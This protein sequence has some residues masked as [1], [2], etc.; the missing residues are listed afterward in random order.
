M[1]L[2]HNG[3]VYFTPPLA[4]GRQSARKQGTSTLL[5]DGVYWKSI[6]EKC[7]RSFAPAPAGGLSKLGTPKRDEGNP[8]LPLS[9]TT[10]AVY[11]SFFSRTHARVRLV[12]LL[13]ACVCVS[14]LVLAAHPL[15][16][17]FLSS[18]LASGVLG[19]GRSRRP[20]RAAASREQGLR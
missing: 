15:F 2:A 7:S 10:A 14:S 19:E 6:V 13:V 12:C 3:Q 18:L 5:A 16:L 20:S 4:S 17:L 9:T 8:A 1:S 11:F